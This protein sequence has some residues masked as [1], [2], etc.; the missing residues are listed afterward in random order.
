MTAAPSPEG[1]T[2]AAGQE[3]WQQRLTDLE[4]PP[5]A[6]QR[7]EPSL[8]RGVAMP[9]LTHLEQQLASGRRAP[10]LALNAPV[11]AGKTSLSAVLAAL[12]PLAGIRLAVASIDDLYL[13]WPERQRSMAGNPFGVSRVPPGSHDLPLLLEAL[14]RW[15]DGAP[16]RLPRFDKTLR[17][18]QGDRSG[19]RG[20][21]ADA[22]LLEGWLLGCRPLGPRRLE[23]ELARLE[24]CGGPGLA[25]PLEQ[26]ERDWLPHWDRNL[27]AY[28][29][30]WDACDGLWLL[31][32]VS[33]RLPMRW[34]LQAEAR[35][36]RAGGGWLPAAELVR[37]VRASLCSLPP[38]LYQQPLECQQPVECQQALECQQPG[39]NAPLPLL[40]LAVLD[41][42]RRCRFRKTQPSESSASSATG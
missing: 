38:E 32:P 40:G 42:R 18:G 11:G 39:E 33:W 14:Q 1:T 25:L 17:G 34:R 6:L 24:G 20:Q 12:A 31:R 19:W 37:L 8:L 3:R 16:L 35:Q 10:L 23:Q 7:L 28:Q 36:R 22:L 41:G 30:L 2:E 5:A 9:L 26:A 21:Q 15:R 4:S 29:P 27:E 13:E